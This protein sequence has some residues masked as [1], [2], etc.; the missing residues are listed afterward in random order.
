MVSPRVVGV[1]TVFIMMTWELNFCTVLSSHHSVSLY[2]RSSRKQ[3][4]CPRVDS[5]SIVTVEAITRHTCSGHHPLPLFRPSPAAPVQAIHPQHLFRPSPAAPVQAITRSTCSGHHPLHLFRQSPAAPVQAITRCPCSG[6]HPQHLFRP[7]P[8]APIQAITRCTCSYPALSRNWNVG[9][10]RKSP[11]SSAA[12]TCSTEGST[13]SRLAPVTVG[14][15]R[16][17]R[18]SKQA[19]FRFSKHAVKQGLAD[20]TIFQFTSNLFPTLS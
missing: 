2:A 19:D 15:R 9:F 10:S 17:W 8:A 11:S 4:F 1:T 18:F 16:Q 7:S 5:V 12:N 13:S 3:P 6:N 20:W 14:G